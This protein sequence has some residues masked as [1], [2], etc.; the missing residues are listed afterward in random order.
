MEKG[1]DYVLALKDNQPTLH[2]DV[3][4]VFDDAR[5]DG[6]NN[7]GHDTHTESDKGHGRIEQ[8]TTTITWD[9]AWLFNTCG[10][11]GMRCLVE[12]VRARTVGEVTTTTTHHFIASV[13]TRKA[14]VMAETCRSHWGVENQLHWRLDVTFNEDQNRLRTGHSAQNMSRLRR[15]GLNMLKRDTTKKMGIKNKRLVAG[16]DHRYLIRLLAG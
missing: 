9:A 8:R 15:L 12:V 1:G 14:S 13:Q 10:W 6:W 7:R 11:A 5:R 3:K 2:E 4:R 16:W